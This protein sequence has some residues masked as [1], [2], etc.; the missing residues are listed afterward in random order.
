MLLEEARRVVCLTASLS[1]PTT[2]LTI[3]VS[4]VNFLS[5]RMKTVLNSRSLIVKD[6]SA[7]RP[8]H[9]RMDEIV[10]NL[11]EIGVRDGKGVGYSGQG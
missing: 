1:R 8:Q 3:I 11:T 4:R 2:G 5:I 6:R 9:R 10:K 7:D